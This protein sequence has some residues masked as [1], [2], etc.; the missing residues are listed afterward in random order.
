MEGF[1]E[2]MR[3]VDVRKIQRK[4]EEMSKVW[5]VSEKR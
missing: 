5:K 3:C 2:D 1:R 4:R